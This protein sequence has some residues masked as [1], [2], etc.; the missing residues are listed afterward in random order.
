M[1]AARSPLPGLALQLQREQKLA[2]FC[3]PEV[4]A[5]MG[6]TKCVL[7]YAKD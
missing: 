7:D 1:L 3:P 5:V 6:P 2:P 4:H